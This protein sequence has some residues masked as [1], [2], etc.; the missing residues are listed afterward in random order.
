MPVNV[1]STVSRV[2]PLAM[3][4]C[5]FATKLLP[6]FQCWLFFSVVFALPSFPEFYT[7]KLFVYPYVHVLVHPE[8][9]LLPGLL[10]LYSGPKT[11]DSTR[12]R[13]FEFF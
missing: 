10:R 1:P 4:A 11:V 9:F 8:L 5:G 13:T 3:L 6:E 2:F 7:Y 12:F